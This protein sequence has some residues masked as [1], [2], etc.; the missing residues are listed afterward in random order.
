MR[1]LVSCAMGAAAMLLAAAPAPAE[2]VVRPRAVASTGTVRFALR[3]TDGVR[4]ASFAIDGRTVDVDRR[5][6]FAC[7]RSGVLRATSLG[8]GEHRLTVRVWRGGR[9]FTLARTVEVDAAPRADDPAPATSTAPVW[10]DEFDGPAGAPPDPARWSFDSGRWRDGGEDERYTDRPENVSLDGDGNLRI[11]A[12]LELGRDA[13][14]TSG[15][16]TTRRLFEPAHGRIEARIKV[17]AGRGL[18]PAFWLLGA[19]AAAWPQSGEID[20]MEVPGNDPFTYYG[21]VHGPAAGSPD[22]DVSE[23]RAVRAP[24]S[25]AGA[26]HVYAIDWRPDAVQFLVDDRPV[27][28][29]VTPS[30]YAALGGTWVYDGPFYLILNLAVGNHWTGKPDA[31]TRFPAT[32][33]VDWVRAFR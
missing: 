15:R 9:A 12:R 7:G 21:H 25:F 31:T 23:E 13:A 6:P 22:T 8:A 17:P 16:I 10:D 1:S 33:L 24:A 20:A 11:V 29:P 3:A 18:L 2:L 26:F 27:G 19:N 5:A 28:P 30:T 32:M 4:K 14:Y